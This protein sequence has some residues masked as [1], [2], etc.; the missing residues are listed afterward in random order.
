MED[1]TNEFEKM[2]R[3]NQL[4]TVS[5]KLKIDERDPFFVTNIGDYAKTGSA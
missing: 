2:D 3:L 1:L 5:N 4:G